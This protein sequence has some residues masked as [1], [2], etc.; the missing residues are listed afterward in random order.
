M[1]S[2]A[3]RQIFIHI[4]WHNSRQPA[5]KIPMSWR[6]F[7]AESTTSFIGVRFARLLSDKV[8]WRIKYVLS[9]ETT[10]KLR[11]YVIWGPCFALLRFMEM[12]RKY[13][14]GFMQRLMSSDNI[15]VKAA[16]V[17]AAAYCRLPFNLW[18]RWDSIIHGLV[19]SAVS[20]HIIISY[21]I[22]LPLYFFTL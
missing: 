21:Y 3:W 2:G 7:R 14:Y 9:V 5:F 20:H 6:Q 10:K 1:H 12:W 4:W 19:E 22:L 17:A 15:V 18:S 16:A 13:I 11:I 8:H